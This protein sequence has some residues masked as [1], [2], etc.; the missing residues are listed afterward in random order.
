MSNKI[1]TYNN[2]ILMAHPK[3]ESVFFFNHITNNTLVILLTN[4][5]YDSNN[6][7]MK[8]F[9]L[10]K[11]ATLICLHDIEDFDISYEI[12]SKLKT[13]IKEYIDISNFEKII[14]HTKI[15]T[16]TDVQNRRLYE[17][18]ISLK[19][20]NHYTIIYDSSL[21]KNILPS[22]QLVWLKKYSNLYEDTNSIFNLYSDTASFVRGLNKIN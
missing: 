16:E 8:N 3:D 17:F 6:N 5:N 20:N 15:K 13:I 12:P 2:I 14:T 21:P 4:S 19:L 10:K 1:Y 18:V 22:H 7:I 9:M 11:G